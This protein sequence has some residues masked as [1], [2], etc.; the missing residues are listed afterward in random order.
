MPPTELTN[1]PLVHLQ[2]PLG[3]GIENCSSFP[4]CGHSIRANRRAPV[5]WKA[6]IQ[7][8]TAQRS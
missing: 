4:H 3:L 1:C 7:A 2:R 6:V 8:V 5:G